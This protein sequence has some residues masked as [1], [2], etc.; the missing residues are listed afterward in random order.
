MRSITRRL[1]LGLALGL[2]AGLAL[3]GPA[4]AQPKNTLVIGLDISDTI[5]FDPARIAQY[6]SPMTAK[7]AYETLVTMTPG[8]YINLK[9]ELATSWEKTADGKGWRFKLRQG[10][11]F[12]SGN[13]M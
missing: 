3:G 10:V 5:T 13:P 12:A 4:G 11:K 7:A 9:P 6:S 8:D 1:A 2:G